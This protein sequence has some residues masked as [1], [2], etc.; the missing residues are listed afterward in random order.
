MIVSVRL[1]SAEGEGPK[2]L[3]TE[4]PAG[5]PEATL[6]FAF[7]MATLLEPSLSVTAET[8]AFAPRPLLPSVAS[9][10]TLLPGR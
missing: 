10:Q 5:R 9:H 6:E 8:P 2:R 1:V 7:P 4:T 3:P